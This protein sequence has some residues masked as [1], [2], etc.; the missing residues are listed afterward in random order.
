MLETPQTQLEQVKR[1]ILSAQVDSTRYRRERYY[2]TG[3]VGEKEDEISW[4]EFAWAPGIS[5]T[6]K[7][8]T[9]TIVT[10][11]SYKVPIP[12]LRLMLP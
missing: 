1:N 5:V 8:P 6:V 3:Q 7:A 10:I 11:P 4:Y 2:H 9:T 12:F